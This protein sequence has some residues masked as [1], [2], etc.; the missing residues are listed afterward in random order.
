M[1]IRLLLAVLILCTSVAKANA[2]TGTVRA[3]QSCEAYQS[4]RKKTNPGNMLISK[5]QTYTYKE[6]SSKP[7]HTKYRIVIKGAKPELRWIEGRCVKP[8]AQKSHKKHFNQVYKSNKGTYRCTTVPGLADSN[9]LAL[10]WQSAFCETR[11]D[12]AE[13]QVRDPN[14]F[15]ANNFTLHGLWPNR[16]NCNRKTGY[17]GHCGTLKTQPKQFCDYPKLDLSDHTRTQLE[18][19]MPSA[20]HGTCLQRHEWHKHGTCQTQMDVSQYYDFAIKLQQEFNDSGMAQLMTENVGKRI[21]S[22]DFFS[23]FDKA[24]GAGTHQKLQLRCKAGDLVDL[25]IHLPKD[26]D[27]KASLKTLLAQAANNFKNSCGTHFLVDAIND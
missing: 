3:I 7:E 8:L 10:S 9:I 6:V 18:I 4:F 25:Y 12:K 1:V 5:G 11:R 15:Q 20:E 26:L 16:D 23:T 22:A 13:C 21:A 2:T 19:S 17:Y 27:Q 24:F 14:S